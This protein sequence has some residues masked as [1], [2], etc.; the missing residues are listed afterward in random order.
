MPDIE[1]YDR[2]VGKVEGF[3]NKMQDNF[4]KILK[5]IKK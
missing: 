4:N 5:K 2:E 1:V 3:F